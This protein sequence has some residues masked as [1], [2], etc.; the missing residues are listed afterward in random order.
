MRFLALILFLPAFSIL[1]WLYLRYPRALPRTPE[2]RRFDGGA[3]ALAVFLAVVSVGV[4]MQTPPAAHGAMWPQIVAVL[5]AFH[6]FPLVLLVA[7]VV[8][9]RRYVVR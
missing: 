3:I 9:M 1:V 4:A 5:A 7:H 6:A 8:R 2:R